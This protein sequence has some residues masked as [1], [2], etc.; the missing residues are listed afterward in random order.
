MIVGV[1]RELSAGETRVALSPQA[2]A[3]LVKMKVE[4]KVESGAG[5]AA[6][7][8]DDAFKAKGAVIAD[9]AAVLQAADVLFT[10]NVPAAGE[11]AGLKKGALVLGHCNPLANAAGMQSL[12]QAT[13]ISLIAMELIPRITRAQAMD[14][15]SSQANLAG[16]KAVI[17]AANYSPKIFPM[18]MT[19]AGTIASA[20]VFVIGVG[21]AGLQAIATAKRLGGVVSAYDVR[22][23]VKEQVQSVGAKFVELPMDTAGAQDAGGY[24]KEQSADQQ[25]KQQEL[26]AKVIA[27]SDVVIT[28]AMVPGKPAPKLIPA[29]AVAAM[30]P[31][32]VIVDMAAAGGGN[33]EL[34]EPGKVVVKH[35]VTIIGL[36]NL[37]ATVP[38]H[39]SAMLANNMVKLLALMV[40]KEGKFA[41]KREDDVIA[42]SLVAYEGEIVHPKVREVLGLG[43]LPAAPANA[44]DAQA[45]QTKQVPVAV[46][47]K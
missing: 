10:V 40:D 25:R 37:P 46:G 33:C 9:R 27:E 5:V 41:I 19:A 24:A 2:A 12:A 15:L 47:G 18:L 21:V 7:F 16:Y 38:L 20:K 28:T 45:A 13:G 3:T 22:P 43:A 1:V 11:M 26:M 30:Q 34:T 36:T 8:E 29:A 32:S 17:M 35:G 39:A 23:A 31:G 42:G 44:A 14:T 6:G 4:V